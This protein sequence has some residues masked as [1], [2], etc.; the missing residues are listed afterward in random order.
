MKVTFIHH[1]SFLVETDSRYLLFD[2]F[3]GEL[4][5]MKD[6]KPLYILASHRH[7]DHFSPVIF[8]L[9]KK[10]PLMTTFYILSSDIW[11]KHVP[12]DMVKQTVFMKA[13]EKK[14]V[15]PGMEIE[16]LKSTDEG[17]AFL[18]H[19]DGQTIYHSGDLNN[20]YWSSEGDDWNQKME[21]LYNQ[22]L[23]RIQGVKIDAGF[24]P[25]DGRQEEGFFLGMDQ[26]MKKVGANIVFPMHCWGDFSV[27]GRLK[28]M[29][30]SKAYRD[31]VADINRDGEEFQI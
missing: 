18:I 2:Y 17:V 16:T 12:E 29:E 3:Q 19:C 20:W 30:R 25:L 11:K 15:F 8:Q 21:R 27:I 28:S 31:K 5:D 9:A 14:E 22:E 13:H 26:F 10:R 6:D 7:G 1:S 24:V 4:P 23:S